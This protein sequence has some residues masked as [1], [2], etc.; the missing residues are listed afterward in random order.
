MYQKAWAAIK[1]YQ[2]LGDLNKRQLS[3]TGSW[4]V[5]DEGVG[6]FSYQKGFSF[7]LSDSQLLSMFLHYIKCS[8]ILFSSYV[9]VQSLS[10][11]QLFVTP[12]TAAYQVSLS[13]SISRSLFK[14]MST[15]LVTPSSH[16]ILCHPLLLL[17]SIFPSIRVFSNE[18]ALHIRWSKYWSFRIS[19]P[20][21]YSGQI[22][23]RIESFGQ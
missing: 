20:N 23:F 6:S 10:R 12:W 22:S 1:K 5:Q 2:I 21:E 16:L 18:L 19:P 4:D 15:E 3:L 13:F 9:V 7:W 14:L 17:P 8:G 11:G